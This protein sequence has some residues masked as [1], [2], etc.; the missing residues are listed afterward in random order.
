MTDLP[1]DLRF[2]LRA[3]AANPVFVVLAVLCL[4]I[5]IGASTMTFTVA[6]GVLRK[7]LGSIDG[8][9]LV[10]VWE[11]HERAPSQW[12]PLTPGRFDD[13]QAATEAQA[14]LAA[15]SEA[16]FVVGPSGAGAR[17]IVVTPMEQV[18]RD[19]FWLQRLFSLWFAIFGVASV[20]LTMAGIYGVLANL[21]WQRAQEMGVRM[22]LGADRAKV[23]LL[24]LREA[25]MFVGTG[26]ALGLGAAYLRA[27]A[28]R[29]T[30]R[31]GAARLAAL[32]GGGRGA[33]R[34]GHGRQ[35]RTGR[36]RRARGSEAAA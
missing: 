5:G 28:A 11:S 33:R 34:R 31:R 16:S 22:A 32:R 9:G 14:E 35:L 12:S 3:L 24:V 30:V 7:P 15:F 17:R 13:W 19:P 20:V 1:S 26:V 18:A 6:N 36:V 2:G 23:L 25:G 27:R 29:P 21:V 8:D 10:E 4:G